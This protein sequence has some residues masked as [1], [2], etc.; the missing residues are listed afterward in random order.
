MNHRSLALCAPL[1]TSIVL[2]ALPASAQNAA[3]KQ[4][5][6]VKVNELAGAPEGLERMLKTG[7]TLS[8]TDSRSV[9]GQPDGL[10]VTIGLK[11]DGTATYRNGFHEWRN[12]LNLNETLTN[13]PALNDVIKTADALAFE[14]IY[15]YYMRPWVG[16][17]VRVTVATPLFRGFDVRPVETTYTI[18]R[19]S[20]ET[21]TEVTRRLPL[22]DPLRPFTLKQTLGPFL[23]P[24]TDEKLTLEM[25]GGIGALQTLAKGQRV[26]QDNAATPQ[27]E[28][29][30]LRNV[31]QLGLEGATEVWGAI[32]DKKVSYKLGIGVLIPLAYSDLPEGDTRSFIDLTNIDIGAGF[33]FK[34][35][36]WA[37]LDYDLKVMRQP[38]LAEG[39]QIRN[40]LMLTLG[41]SHEKK[42]L[43]PQPE[44]AP[45]APPQK[46]ASRK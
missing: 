34:L 24:F 19:T 7:L 12:V 27:V 29:K 36:E 25:R 46:M 31:F 37:T 22:T 30:E 42:P 26:L 4:F 17:F 20:G 23:R 10:T 39:F 45:N 33:S 40:G 2:S 28:V 35:V 8:L 14:S 3:S 32:Y 18:A 5:V 15:L 41:L 21:E 13:T 38:Q 6:D 11:F 16:P 1:L 9:V 43:T 44:K